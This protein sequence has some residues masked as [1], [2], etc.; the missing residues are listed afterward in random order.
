MEKRGCE[1]RI[2]LLIIEIRLPQSPDLDNGWFTTEY[3]KNKKFDY[4]LTF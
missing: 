1:K 2:V 3:L 4:L